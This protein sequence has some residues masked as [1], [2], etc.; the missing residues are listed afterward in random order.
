M[1]KRTQKT[2]GSVAAAAP[3]ACAPSADPSWEMQS[4]LECARRDGARVAVVVV[5]VNSNYARQA[6]E[7]LAKVASDW[8]GSRSERVRFWPVAS[9]RFA[10]AIA[11]IGVASHARKLAERFTR[12]LDPRICPLL[13]R[14]LPYAWC[15]V[16]LFPDEGCDARVLVARAEQALERNRSAA[17]RR[18]KPVLPR[19]RAPATGPLRPAVAP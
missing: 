17:A 19:R 3:C 10:L 15:G 13:H 8:E 4:A 18:R 2:D 7:R 9:G 1:S 6:Q 16:S 14:A 5:E 12:A 11:P